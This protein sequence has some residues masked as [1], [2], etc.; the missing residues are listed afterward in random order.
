MDGDENNW[1]HFSN[2]HNDRVGALAPKTD[3][4]KVATMLFATILIPLVL[5]MEY[6]YGIGE[7][8]QRWF[9]K[10]CVTH[11]YNF[12]RIKENC[13]KFPWLGLSDSQEKKKL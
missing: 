12:C 7:Q 3:V 13:D 10:T 9:P 2:S 6:L 11:Y 4:G 1:F 8:H 5:Y